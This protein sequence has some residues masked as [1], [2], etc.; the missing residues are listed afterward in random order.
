MIFGARIDGLARVFEA[1]TL[2]HA[3]VCSVV[4]AFQ[5]EVAEGTAVAGDFVVCGYRIVALPTSDN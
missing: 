4:V 2:L 3:K 5:R 1:G